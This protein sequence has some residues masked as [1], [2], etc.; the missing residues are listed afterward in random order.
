MQTSA[1]VS[2]FRYIIVPEAER[3]KFLNAAGNMAAR[4]AVL[5]REDGSLSMVPVPTCPHIVLHRRFPSCTDKTPPEPSTAD[6][7]ALR[8]GLC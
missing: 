7:L 3:P 5:S 8:E 2:S 1:S 4:E 6:G